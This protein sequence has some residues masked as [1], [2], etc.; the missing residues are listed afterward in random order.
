MAVENSR[1]KGILFA[2]LTAFFWGFLAIALKV[3][4]GVLDPLTI[5]WFRFL[6]AFLILL[7]IFAIKKPEYLVIL[8]NP[9]LYIIVASLGLGINYLAFLYGLKLTTP[10][11]A[12]VIIQLG[13]IFL[14]IVGLIFFREKISKR[15]GLGFIVAGS[16]MYI[17]YRESLSQIVAREELF[18]MGII[19]VV[20]AAMAWVVYATFQKM[21]VKKYPTQQL[22]LFLFGLP[23]LLFA[24]FINPSGFFNLSLNNWLLL[25]YLGLN[26]LIA[27]GSLA[28][29]FKYLEASKVSIIV[30][31]NPIITFIIMGILTYMEVKW[32]DPEIL[33]T[34]GLM[35]AFLVLLGAIMA[36][37]VAKPG[38][39]KD[40]RAW[41]RSGHKNELDD[42]V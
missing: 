31:M 16:G 42:Q 41:F 36:I 6:V 19:W 9:P 24:P 5:V 28:Y 39:K 8:K 12:Q 18:N 38:K 10:G 27:Y 32:I 33:S 26:T 21:L 3:A 20:V 11:T 29:A 2:S 4:S 1:I 22:N 13:P 25:I 7:V 23:V 40:I 37:A 15:Q 30:T 34:R 35:A 17:F 14:G